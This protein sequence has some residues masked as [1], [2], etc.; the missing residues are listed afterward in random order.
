VSD[1]GV[2]APE[3]ALTFQTVTDLVAAARA[4]KPVRVDLAKITEA[5]SAGL[6]LLVSL[7]RDFVARGEKLAI[8]HMPDGMSALADLYGV[9]TLFDI[10]PP[11]S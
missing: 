11:R 3:G 7:A 8:I 9:A 5:D 1:A 10:A 4:T 6:A 2:W